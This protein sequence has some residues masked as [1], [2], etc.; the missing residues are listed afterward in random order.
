MNL[1]PPF[2]SGWSK[3]IQNFISSRVDA[4]H[5]KGVVLGLSGGIDSAV[6]AR[7]C[8]ESLG[9]K[10]VHALM[11]P[12]NHSDT[13][14]VKDA[15]EYA[16]ELGI[17]HKKTDI[18]PILE[19]FGKAVNTSDRVAQGNLKART[20]MVLLYQYANVNNLI[21][22][23]TSNKTEMLVGYFTKFGDGASDI[24]PIGDLYKTQV[25]SLS[26]ELCMPEKLVSKVPTAGLWAGQTDEQELGITYVRLDKI[27]YG[28]ELGMNAEQIASR[29]GES[30]A[31]VNRMMERVKRNWHKRNPALVPKIGI[32]TIGIDWR[33]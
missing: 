32:R 7:L 12:D 18:T 10:F 20:R 27:L 31:E 33:D 13:S 1:T 2:D 19:S 3:V 24:L 30:V 5:A 26:K 6:I 4:A 22:V 21:V 14:D 29:T 15:E 23:G 28:I 16:K 17:I 11:L 25:W 9:N 8:V